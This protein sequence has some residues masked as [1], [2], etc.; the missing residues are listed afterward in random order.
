MFNQ[1]PCCSPVRDRH[2]GT[3]TKNYLS[4]RSEKERRCQ[5]D[6]MDYVGGEGEGEEGRVTER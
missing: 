2:R 3:K 6:G 5:E 1:E 4:M